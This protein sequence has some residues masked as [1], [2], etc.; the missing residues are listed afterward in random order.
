MK[1]GRQGRAMCGT[2][3]SGR[4]WG[5]HH[6]QEESEHRDP[7]PVSHRGAIAL[8]L[9]AV[10]KRGKN[11]QEGASGRHVFKAESPVFITEGRGWG[12]RE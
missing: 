4:V 6:P 8:D 7:G 11:E 5:T 9:A 3:Q 10:N 1:P 2:Q 12:Q